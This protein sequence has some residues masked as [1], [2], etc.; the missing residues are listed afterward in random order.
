VL[1]GCEQLLAIKEAEGDDG[2]TAVMLTHLAT[3]MEMQ[4]RVDEAEPLM[5]RAL[6]LR[7]A[8]EGADSD[9]AAAALNNVAL[10]RHHLHRLGSSS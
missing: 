4:Q 1:L 9:G 7:Q 3:A 5:R 6:A 10:V 2:G 8:G